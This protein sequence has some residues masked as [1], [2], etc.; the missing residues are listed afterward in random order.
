M[1]RWVLAIA[2]VVGSASI[3]HAALPADPGVSGRTS[4]TGEF[5][6]AAPQLREPHFAQTVI[7]MVQHNRGGAFGIVI[8][9]PL[10]EQPLVSLIEAYGADATNVSASVRVFWGGPVTPDISFV[11]HGTDYRLADT[12]DV[13]G[14]VSLSAGPDVLRDI[15]LSRGPNKSLIA[16]GYAGWAAAQLEGEIAR[17]DWYSVPED[18]ALVFDEDRSKVWTA[19]MARHNADR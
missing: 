2:A 15:G 6:V 9:R 16:F 10:D 19:A 8:N 5:L 12:V 7:L 13:D 11:I 4:L 18:P 1:K 14:H 3:L 17:G